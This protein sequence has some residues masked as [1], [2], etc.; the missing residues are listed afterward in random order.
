MAEQTSLKLVALVGVAGA[1]A[2]LAWPRSLARQEIWRLTVGTV[3]VGN[4]ED[5][6]G[7]ALCGAVQSGAGRVC[8]A[9]LNLRGHGSDEAGAD[10]ENGSGELHCERWWTMWT[11]RELEG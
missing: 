2:W 11:T 9:L 7:A 4:A 8:L 3:E 10:G 1:S 5:I 6:G